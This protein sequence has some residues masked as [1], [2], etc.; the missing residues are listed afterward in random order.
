ML[1]NKITESWETLPFGK[2]RDGLEYK[3][4]HHSS[5]HIFGATYLVLAPEHELVQKLKSQIKN[6]KEVEKY[7]KKSKK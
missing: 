1:L 6:W 2:G 5:R 7:I 4:F 3:S